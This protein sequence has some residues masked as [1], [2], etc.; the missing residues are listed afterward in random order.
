[1]E[2]RVVAD[3]QH[4]A[5]PDEL[6]ALVADQA[7]NKDQAIEADAPPSLLVYLTDGHGPALAAPPPF[8]VLWALHEPGRARTPASWGE[9]AYLTPRS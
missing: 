4:A 3:A 5:R 1:M 9:V 7:G 2:P 8:L 6:A